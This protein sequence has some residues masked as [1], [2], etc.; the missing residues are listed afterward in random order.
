VSLITAAALS[1]AAAI[2]V[3]VMMPSRAPSRGR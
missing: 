3:V 1:A 2:A